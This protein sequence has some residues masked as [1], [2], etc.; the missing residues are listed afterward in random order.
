M[1]SPGGNNPGNAGSVKP[2]TVGDP[3][4]MPGQVSMQAP[5]TVGGVNLFTGVGVPAASLG[6][7]GDFYFRTDGGAATC[8]YQKRTGAWVA[9]SA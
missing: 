8:I 2:P 9:T 4:T 5:V 1:P 6:N 3:I 7:N